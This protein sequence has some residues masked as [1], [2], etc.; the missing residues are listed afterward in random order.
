MDTVY[1]NLYLL[2]W[3]NK[4]LFSTRSWTNT[5]KYKYSVMV[6]DRLNHMKHLL[7]LVWV[8]SMQQINL[9]QIHRDQVLQ[10]ILHKIMVDYLFLV[11]TSKHKVV[12][13]QH[14]WVVFLRLEPI[15]TFQQRLVK[16]FL[17]LFLTI[18]C[19]TMLNCIYN[20]VF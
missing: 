4:H 18:F 2:Q 19:I 15:C 13:V 11:K 7:K 12:K 14:S 8:Q 10:L 6:M 9:L 5:T 16:E 17:L 20:M 3:E 1:E